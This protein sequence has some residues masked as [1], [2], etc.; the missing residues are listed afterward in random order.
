MGVLKPSHNSS[1]RLQVQL[2]LQDSIMAKDLRRKEGN[3]C[4][5]GLAPRAHPPP[6]PPEQAGRGSCSGRALRHLQSQEASGLSCWGLLPGT[7]EPLTSH[8]L[9]RGTKRTFLGLE[10]GMGASYGGMRIPGETSQGQ[11]EG[12]V[13]RASNWQWPH[14]K[15]LTSKRQWGS[16]QGQP[17]HSHCST[18]CEPGA[19]SSWGTATHSAQI[20][21]KG[22]CQKI[23]PAT[24][25]KC[26]PVSDLDVC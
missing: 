1:W 3:T 18:T 15:T 10:A 26:R 21:G 19:R 23:T 13:P 24:E 17:T 11:V 5:Q 20:S 7:Q 4:D 2:L 9:A 25:R 6:R 22:T 16:L 12:S 14:R 8:S